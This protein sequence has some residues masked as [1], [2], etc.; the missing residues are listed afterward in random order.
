LAETKKMKLKTVLPRT[1]IGGDMGFM[2][3]I[4]DTEGNIIG[5]WSLK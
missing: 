4:K 1:E 5:I 2:A 3:R